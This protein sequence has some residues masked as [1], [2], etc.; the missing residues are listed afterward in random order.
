MTRLEI[1][2]K[3]CT[4]LGSNH[5]Y[6]QPPESFKMVYPAIVY[7]RAAIQNKFADDTVYHQAIKY[8][9]TVIDENPDSTIVASVSQLPSC[10]FDRHFASGNLNHDVFTIYF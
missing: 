8:Q 5:V 6:Y 9:V 2:T 1:H 10:R 7:Q 3:L 4:L